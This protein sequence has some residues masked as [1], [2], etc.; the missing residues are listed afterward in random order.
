[1]SSSSGSDADLDSEVFAEFVIVLDCDRD[2]AWPDPDS[3]SDSAI[4]LEEVSEEVVK[5]WRLLGVYREWL[6]LS[7]GMFSVYIEYTTVELQPYR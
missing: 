5:F 6:R 2:D 1:L 3:I 7:L 4:E